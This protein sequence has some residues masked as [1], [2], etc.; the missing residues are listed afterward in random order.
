LEI[1][2]G[3]KGSSW[4]AFLCQFQRM[5]SRYNWSQRRKL[6]RLYACLG[7]KALE[8]ATEI[9]ADSYKKLK[10]TMGK[11]FSKKEDPLTARRQLQYVRQKEEETLEE[12]SQRVQF[13]AMEGH[14]GAHNE[15]I[16]QISVESFL[17][18]CKDKEAAKSAMEKDPLNIYKALKL[19]KAAIS[20]RKALFGSKS[21]T[22]TRQVTVDRAGIQQPTKR[23]A[24]E[25][26]QSPIRSK[27]PEAQETVKLLQSLVSRMEQLESARPGTSRAPSRSPSPASRG[28]KDGRPSQFRS[29][30]PTNITCYKCGVKGHISRN[31]TSQNSPGSDRS[32]PKSVVCYTCKEAG[33][34]STNC[35]NK[36][37]LNK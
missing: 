31:C 14:P 1:F 2:K 5:T 17:R 27:S 33:H 11:R 18:A 16:D 34:Y 10:S 20:I 22:L 6:D 32:E 7:G 3:D 25:G 21:P 12:L 30:S 23:V 37:P 4:E 9:G 19:V 28:G 29:P 15:T 36:I 13:L 24:F 8:F 35:P 26:V